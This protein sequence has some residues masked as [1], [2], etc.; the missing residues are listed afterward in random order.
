MAEESP[1]T[2]AEQPE[3]TQL[4]PEEAPVNDQD[5]LVQGMRVFFQRLQVQHQEQDAAREHGLGL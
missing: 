3:L 1:Q 4:H 2:Q 5:P